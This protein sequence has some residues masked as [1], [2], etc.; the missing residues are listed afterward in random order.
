MK[1]LKK[2]IQTTGKFV[3][4]YTAP[5]HA[6]QPRMYA[7]LYYSTTT[8]PVVDKFLVASYI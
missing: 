5:G 3:C 8:C 7:W 4:L 6:W 1:M 2:K